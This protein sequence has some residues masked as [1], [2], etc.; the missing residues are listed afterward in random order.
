MKYVLKI[1]LGL[2]LIYCIIYANTH[3]QKIK[4]YL[5]KINELITAKYKVTFTRNINKPNKQLKLK[6]EYNQEDPVE[7]IKDEGKTILLLIG[8]VVLIGFMYG[9]IYSIIGDIYRR[10]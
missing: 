3:P 6:Y 9:S 10:R 5:H 7:K 4:F 8:I 2:I 1:I